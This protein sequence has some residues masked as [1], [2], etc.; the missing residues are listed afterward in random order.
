MKHS[1]MKHSAMKRALAKRAEKKATPKI[2]SSLDTADEIDQAMASMQHG[3]PD[4]SDDEVKAEKENI[5][6]A[7]T[8]EDPNDTEVNGK[9]QDDLAPGK[10]ANPDDEDS[11]PNYE[12]A[13]DSVIDGMTDADMEMLQ[14]KK[15]LS[16]RERMMLAAYLQK[17]NKA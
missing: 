10:P 12:T 14:M 4:L 15:N 5:L 3:A 17:K 6:G 8:L 13:G 7:Q 1:A 2:G 16:L 11:D 9:E